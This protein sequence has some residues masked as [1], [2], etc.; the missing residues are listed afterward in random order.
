MVQVIKL[1]IATKFYKGYCTLSHGKID[2]TVNHSTIC[3][4]LGL[5]T[6]VCAL[7]VKSLSH[8]NTGLP[9]LGAGASERKQLK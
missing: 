6:I 7:V 4:L 2:S 5:V 9:G 1:F 8:V 3:H